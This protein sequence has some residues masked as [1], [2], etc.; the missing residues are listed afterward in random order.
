MSVGAV[1]GEWV[2]VASALALVAGSST[3]SSLCG[4]C[5]RRSASQT[6]G[7]Q[8]SN[9]ERSNAG[10]RGIQD[11]TPGSTNRAARGRRGQGRPD[12]PMTGGILRTV[13]RRRPNTGRSVRFDEDGGGTERVGDGAGDLG[14]TPDR[15]TGRR[16]QLDTPAQQH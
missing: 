5:A 1:V 3:V 16:L 6:G 8:A 9:G 2:I 4:A 13:Q 7:R 15:Q 10:A 14:A 11:G 12:T